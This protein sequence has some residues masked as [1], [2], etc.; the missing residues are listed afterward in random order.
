MEELRRIL[1][2]AGFEG[3]E[4]FIASG[5]LVLDARPGDEAESEARI[6]LILREALGFEVATFI[7]PVAALTAIVAANP[8]DAAGGGK[9]QVGFVRTPVGDDAARN[10]LALANPD[11]DFHVAGRDLYWHT[12]TSIHESRVSGPM[13]ERAIGGPCTWRNINTIARIAAKYAV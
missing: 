4:T 3:I 10:V 9:V 13:L 5:N 12:H 7:R 2:A 11:D 1:A 6:E 8:F